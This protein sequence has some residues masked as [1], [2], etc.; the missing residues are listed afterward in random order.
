MKWVTLSG[1]IRHIG[2]LLKNPC[3]RPAN[4]GHVDS[5]ELM[6][7]KD[8]ISKACPP[9]KIMHLSDLHVGGHDE[10][11]WRRIKATVAARRPDF[12]VITGDITDHPFPL[13]RVSEAAQML[14][15]LVPVAGRML[16]IP[17]NHD[18]RIWGLFGREITIICGVLG[19]IAY[20]RCTSVAYG[21]AALFGSIVCW[22]SRYLFRLASALQ[23]WW[24]LSHAHHNFL[25]DKEIVLLFNSNALLSHTARG[26]GMAADVAF[27]NNMR[28]LGKNMGYV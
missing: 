6:K 7:D 22:W 1:T 27:R 21:L 5:Q 10:E 18:Y 25:E 12:T 13:K 20:F 16:V 9:I 19:L 26:R 11:A 15:T 24:S 28:Q 23:S 14:R 17:G 3:G 8:G 2:A 4:D